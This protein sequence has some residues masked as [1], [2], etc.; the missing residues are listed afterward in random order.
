MDSGNKGTAL[1]SFLIISFTL[2]GVVDGN[3]IVE[4]NELIIVDMFFNCV[5]LLPLFVVLSVIF[6]KE[7]F[8]NVAS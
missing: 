2:S 4:I 6:D 5:V 8:G 3:N 1:G 7:S